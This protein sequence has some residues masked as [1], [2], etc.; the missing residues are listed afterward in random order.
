M[1][2]IYF[3]EGHLATAKI[4]QRS[5]GISRERFRVPAGD[6]GRDEDRT[7]SKFAGSARYKELAAFADTK[8]SGTPLLTV[9]QR[10]SPRWKEFFD[11]SN[12]SLD[13]GG[14]S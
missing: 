4:Q 13:K 1:V 8:F 14:Y 6:Q 7:G 3:I 9:T 12:L 5:A 11:S 2:R 10:S